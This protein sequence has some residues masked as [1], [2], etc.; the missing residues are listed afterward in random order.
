LLVLMSSNLA[1]LDAYIT[2]FEEVHGIV[3]LPHNQDSSTMFDQYLR[4]D[5]TGSQ[6]ITAQVCM[7]RTPYPLLSSYLTPRLA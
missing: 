1:G 5:S 6:H 4:P 7:E 3:P 2:K